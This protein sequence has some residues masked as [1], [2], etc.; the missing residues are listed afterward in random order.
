MFTVNISVVFYKSVGQTYKEML[1]RFYYFEFQAFL[2]LFENGMQAIN[3][4][5]IIGF[6]CDPVAM[7][8]IIF[9]IGGEGVGY[10]LKCLAKIISLGIEVLNP[11]G[12]KG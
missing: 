12:M 6:L 4:G 11:L 8:F 1:R 5:K 9:E 3:A 7:Y 10:K 2:A